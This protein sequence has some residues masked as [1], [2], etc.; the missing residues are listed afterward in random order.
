[1][2]LSV[3]ASRSFII[4][5]MLFRLV[6]MTLYWPLYSVAIVGGMTPL[7]TLST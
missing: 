1:M 7:D 5:T 6:L 2:I 4:A 3:S